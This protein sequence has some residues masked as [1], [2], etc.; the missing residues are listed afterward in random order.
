ME[1]VA[2]EVVTGKPELDTG[3]AEIAEAASGVSPTSAIPGAGT[4]TLQM[5]VFPAVLAR[6]ATVDVCCV[7]MASPFELNELACPNVCPA[8]LML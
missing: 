1:M 5:F 6:Q 4:V 8:Q 2:A 7:P 3:C